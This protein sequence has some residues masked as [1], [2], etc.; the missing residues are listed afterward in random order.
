MHSQ[1]E[2]EQVSQQIE[3]IS[4]EID[5]YFKITL[6]LPSS[7]LNLKSTQSKDGVFRV[8]SFILVLFKFLNIF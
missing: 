3:P 5:E 7:S 8:C 4:I 6:Q 1:V 2:Q